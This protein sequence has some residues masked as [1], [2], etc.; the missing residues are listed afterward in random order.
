MLG[1]IGFLSLVYESE[2][3][4]KNSESGE[5]CQDPKDSKAMGFPL[6]FS[7]KLAWVCAYNAEDGGVDGCLIFH[8]NLNLGTS[9]V[10]RAK[11]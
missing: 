1:L 7:L 4:L 5:L 9:K 6:Q 11:L 2:M 3:I 8:G 10:F